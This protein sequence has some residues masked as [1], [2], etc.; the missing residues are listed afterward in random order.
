[1]KKICSKCCESLPIDAFYK[2]RSKDSDRDLR[3]RQAACKECQL[4]TQQTV[5]SKEDRRRSWLW[6]AYK[7]TPEDYNRML[8][9]A[10][11]ACEICSAVPT[12]DKPLCVDHDHTTG[13][14]RGLLCDHCNRGLGYFK[15]N[16]WNLT[17]A[18]R[19]L[20]TCKK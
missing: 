14:I 3:N 15:D 18:R 19:Y 6:N 7:I 13:D 16:A 17:L 8:D 4:K 11:G 10:K 9:Y 20:N 1:M 12:P 2:K 5:Y